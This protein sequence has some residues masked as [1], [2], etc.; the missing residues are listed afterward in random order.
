MKDAALMK[1]AMRQC[2]NMTSREQR[3]SGDWYS[4]RSVLCE[5]EVV[6]G[7]GWCRRCRLGA[8]QL[9]ACRNIRD[10]TTTPTAKLIL[11]HGT[12][13]LISLQPI[14]PDVEVRVQSSK[15][16]WSHNDLEIAMGAPSGSAK[17]SNTQ[18]AGTKPQSP[19]SAT[20]SLHHWLC[21]FASS[22]TTYIYDLTP[23]QLD[24]AKPWRT[25]V[26]GN[27]FSRHPCIFARAHTQF[28]ENSSSIHHQGSGINEKLESRPA[29]IAPPRS[30]KEARNS[31]IPRCA[32]QTRLLDE[33]NL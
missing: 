29:K 24:A 22:V 5:G 10:R 30:P 13:L 9:I 18:L 33:P 23:L 26:A 15:V 32:M 12:R 20:V 11:D 4:G 3:I 28:Y 16:W 21:A 25:F 8:F 27:S 14:P 1:A 31:P 6:I 19:R 7:L 17:L 2:G